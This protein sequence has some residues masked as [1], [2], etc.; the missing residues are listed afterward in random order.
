MIAEIILAGV[1]I[2]IGLFTLYL[3]VLF[4][5]DSVSFHERIYTAFFALF[6]GGTFA[7]VPM[8]PSLVSVNKDISYTYIQPTHIDKTNNTTF[9]IYITDDK[10]LISK[11]SCDAEYWNSDN[12]MVKVKSGKNIWGGE[13]KDEYEIG[14]FEN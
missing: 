5:F 14:I 6:L 7:F 3:A 4:L 1:G 8:I 12:I 13:V 9:V 10:G 11:T 2:C